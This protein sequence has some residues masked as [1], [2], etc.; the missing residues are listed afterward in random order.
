[1]PDYFAN[2]KIRNA[3]LITMINTMLPMTKSGMPFPSHHTKN[4]AT[5]TPE[6]IMMSLEE[7]MMLA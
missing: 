3:P 5:I 7:N 4:P 6:L 1:M 2:F